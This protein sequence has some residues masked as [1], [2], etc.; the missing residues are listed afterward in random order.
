MGLVFLD[1]HDPG[2]C[3]GL[4]R[5]SKMRRFSLAAETQNS[6][7]AR[8]WLPFKLYHYLS[9]FLLVTGNL[10]CSISSIRNSIMHLRMANLFL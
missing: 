3:P 9:L 8:P 5:K 1:V 7:Q 10:V 6:E 2:R 4:A